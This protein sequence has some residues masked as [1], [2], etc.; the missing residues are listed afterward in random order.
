MTLS[1]PRRILAAV[2]VFIVCFLIA[3]TIIASKETVEAAPPTE[4]SW[5]V[6]SVEASL[7]SLSP[8]IDLYGTVTTSSQATLT[9]AI[10]ADV[11]GV[12]ARAGDSVNSLQTLIQLDDREARITELQALA[13]YHEATA[14]LSVEKAAQATERSTLEKEQAV[15]NRADESLARIKGLH[16][17]G[18]ASQANLDDA[19]DALTRAEQTFS[20]RNLAV[21]QQ[22]AKLKARSASVS[23]AKAALERTTLDRMRA[24]VKAPFDAYVVNVAVAV[25][26]R[27]SPGQ[28]LATVY[29]RNDIDVKAQIPNRHLPIVRKATDLS[30]EE[31]GSSLALHAYILDNHR[32]IANARLKRLA[33]NA[34][35][36]TGGVDA[37]FELDSHTLELGRHVQLRL[38]LPK[39]D[40]VLAV[41][42]D[43]LYGLN[44]I[45]KIDDQN[46][47]KRIEV[48]VLGN[49]YDGDG[50]Q[51]ILVKPE[52]LAAGERV[53]AVQL[54]NAAT[55]ML[56]ITGSTEEVIDDK[57]ADAIA[58]NP[59]SAQ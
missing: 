31:G 40:G 4:R 42:T 2:I 13:Q 29:A 27:V 25:G 5:R 50:K 9:S 26:D 6:H 3:K 46:R 38:L 39:V 33:R 37:W 51:M 7:D 21:Q 49:W 45:F 48:E 59:S 17:R 28:P 56:V 47:L 32:P 43:T 53:L 36:T 20:A 15:M 57:P 1:R 34:G 41:N 11:S 35:Q 54:P 24:K 16:K 44:H 30:A 18:L 58:A 12:T 23:R 52:Q 10:L 19:K 22:D 14:A 55:G 8:A